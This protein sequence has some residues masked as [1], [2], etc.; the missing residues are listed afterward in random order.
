V[1]HYHLSLGKAPA[2]AKLL[3][4][5]T[6]ALRT[7]RDARLYRGERIQ[8]HEYRRGDKIIAYVRWDGTELVVRGAEPLYTPI[9]GVVR[10]RKRNRLKVST[11]TVRLS[12]YTAFEPMPQTP[13][14]RSLDDVDKGHQVWAVCWYDPTSREYVADKVGVTA[15]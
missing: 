10:S 14:A 3:T 2:G 7:P 8:L 1:E 9:R 5:P 13:F 12:E 6:V 15:A 11:H 4:G